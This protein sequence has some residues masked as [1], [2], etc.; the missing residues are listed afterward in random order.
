[1]KY[2]LIQGTVCLRINPADY[3]TSL[4]FELLFRVIFII[5]DYLARKYQTLAKHA[6]IQIKADQLVDFIDLVDN[7]ITVGKC[8]RCSLYEIPVV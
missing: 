1:M 4:N 5:P 2:W 3:F 6:V 8:N 7:C